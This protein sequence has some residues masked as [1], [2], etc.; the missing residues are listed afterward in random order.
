MHRRVLE[1]WQAWRGKAAEPDCGRDAPPTQAAHLVRGQAAEA[2]AAAYLQA[3]G[4]GILARNVRFRGGEVDLIADD[5]GC[6]VFVEVRLRQ[7]SRFGG[8]AASITAA[9]Q[10]RIRRAAAWWL[11]NEGRRWRGH[12]CRFDAVILD[13]LDAGQLTWLRAAFTA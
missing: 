4:L 9:K 10:Q 5:G 6:I 3:H 1:A 8:A 12:R 2:L 13:R 7:D 11:Q